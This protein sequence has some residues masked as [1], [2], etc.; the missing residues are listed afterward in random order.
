MSGRTAS[1]VVT[2]YAGLQVQISSLGVNIPIG[3]GT[4]RCK[5][6][7]V[8][9]LDFRSV[10]H[11][12]AGGKGGGAP[13]GY[14]YYASLVMAIC[15]G[16][17][18]AITLV[19]AGSTIY[20]NGAKSA[21]A[22]INLSLSTGAIGQ[23]VWSY[24]TSHHPDHAIGYSGL[25]TVYASNYPLGGGAV[26][27][28]HSFEVVRLLGFGVPGTEDADP[29][30]VVTDFFTNTRTGV[31]SWGPGLLGD[32]T[33][34]Q[35]YCLAAGLLVSPVIDG[36][37]GASDF[38]T[39]LLRATN[40]T[41]VWSE[42]VLK[43]IPYGDTALTGAGKTYTPNVTPAYS[44][45]DDAFVVEKDV[46]PLLVDIMDQSD[47]Y[48][49]VQLEYLDRTNQ[50]NMAIALASDAANVAQY[51]MRRKDTDTVHCICTPSVAALSA[52]LFLQRTLYVRG[53]YKFKLCWVFAL[54]EPGDIVDLTD[55]GLGL[56]AYPVRITQID[57][58]EHYG[59][60]ITAED[61]QIGVAHAPHYTMEV[62]AG[63]QVNRGVD[64]GGVEANLLLWSE[65]L[66]NA[67]WTQFDTTITP[68]ATTEPLFGAAT[69][70]A[71]IPAAVS[72]GHYA[73]QAV[74]VF[75]GI[76][77]TFAVYL[78]PAGR[79][80]VQ[81]QI[82]DLVASG[83]A[84]DVDT[85]TGSITQAAGA[86]GTTAFDPAGALTS[87]GSG[88]C[89][90]SVTVTFEAATTVYPVIAVLDDLGNFTWTGDGLNGVYVWGAQLKQGV[91]LPPYAVTGATIAGPYLFNPPSVL[92]NGGNATWAAVA[93]GANW[94]G[95][96]VW[97][98]IDGANYQQIGVIE[99]SARYGVATAAFASGADPDTTHTLS[100][101]VGR[102]GGAL[103][104]GSA[105]DADA[106]T[107][108]CLA[109]GELIAYENATL[110]GP[111][112]YNLGT[113]IRRGVLGTPIA[114][115]AAGAPFVRLD[116]AIFDFPY[117]ATQQGA[118]VF[119]KFQSFNLW[120]EAAQALSDCAVY[121]ITP[122]PQGA[123]APS[124][125]AW[126]PTGGTLSIGGIVV[127]AIQ[128]NGASDNPSAS[129][130]VFL[131]RVHGASGWVDAGLAPNSATQKDITSIVAATH[132][133][134]GV[135]YVVN[136]VV[137]AISTIGAVTTGTPG[138]GALATLGSVDFATSQVTNKTADHIAYTSGPSVDSLQPAAAGATRNVVTYA[139][140]PPSSPTD[141][142]IW[143]DTAAMPY[144]AYMRV[145]GAWQAAAAYVTDTGQITDGAGLGNRAIWTG[146]TGAGKPA[147]DATKNVTTYNATAPA[148]PTDGDIWVDTASNPAIVY[149]RDAG[150]WRQAANLVQNTNQ[151]I[152]GA[153]LG[154]TAIWASVSSRPANVAALT[155]GETIDNAVLQ[156]ALTGGSVVPATFAGRG[157]LASKNTVGPGDFS[158][159]AIK[160]STVHVGLQV[161]AAGGGST[162]AISAENLILVDA[163][164][165]GV[166]TGSISLAPSLT[167]SGLGG[168]DAGSVVAAAWYFVWAVSDG[169]SVNAVF[170]LSSTAPNNSGFSS[171]AYKARI[172]AVVTDG[173]SHIKAFIQN[174]HN[175]QYLNTGSGLPVMANGPAG[176]TAYLPN[177]A[178]SVIGFVPSTAA[179]IE[180]LVQGVGL[181]ST[182]VAPNANYGDITTTNPAPLY[183]GWT[184]GAANAWSVMAGVLTLESTDIYWYANNGNS[185]LY[186]LGWTDTF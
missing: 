181:R 132:Y 96:N 138:Y 105:A 51:G 31:P 158:S 63:Y 74:A 178:I 150:S 134:V 6:N 52:Q 33:Q 75:P 153:N 129:S 81:L 167:T 185:H 47:A 83:V 99:A 49:V 180:V 16:P 119:V 130:V 11:K 142:D 171:Y 109:D 15:E 89:R 106:S 110:T 48:N 46:A 64:P 20:K 146:V 182:L 186:C 112:R 58:D 82:S 143:T 84:M 117:L 159:G 121:T 78:K 102:S 179:Q 173:S 164:F 65:D 25:A 157:A 113:Y 120:G 101:D 32:L 56:A 133:D 85:S 17:I 66:T 154:Q 54:L 71:L 165:N 118:P 3:W 80:L 172:G 68:N 144:V 151:V 24:L 37:R 104:G 169:T 92:T 19:Y 128:I 62:G 55:A 86:F 38:L 39:E 139:S 166:Y 156:G 123:A 4:F 40:S 114:S 175:V 26:S 61:A 145:G 21:L 9:Y 116:N 50:Y 107:T 97:T 91:D 135:A 131:Y 149:L 8:D 103:I 28:N 76:P 27:P 77:Y 127:P 108:L 161:S 36:Q 177:V 79:K 14:S 13:T 41:C 95:A 34:Y 174:G 1:H 7:L 57:E 100:V 98:S 122:N 124:S 141:G 5:C 184:S 44:L 43:F 163:S 29:S 176:A 59:L 53:Q 12:A 170:S 160:N 155:G 111:C 126:T 87:V 183:G 72:A 88:W 136:G 45:D 137:G 147:D 94:G 69:A 90:A 168:L 10:P 30:L 152:D 162:A 70:D 42:G 60:S 35:D 93:G 148:S 67:A 125:S 73:W 115:H 18:D 22:Q 140:S 23:P 2:R